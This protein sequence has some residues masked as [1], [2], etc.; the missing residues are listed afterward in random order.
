[1]KELDA[2]MKLLKKG[3]VVKKKRLFV[4]VIVDQASYITYIMHTLLGKECDLVESKSSKGENRL[5]C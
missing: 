3:L 5:R 4:I 2:C 1:M